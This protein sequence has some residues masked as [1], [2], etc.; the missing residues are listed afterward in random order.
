MSSTIFKPYFLDSLPG[1][2]G[3]ALL[4]KA[5]HNESIT[6]ILALHREVGRRCI[7]VAVERKICFYRIFRPL[8]YSWELLTFFYGRQRSTEF[9]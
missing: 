4:G 9:T 6:G 1:R 8:C 2:I 3:K 5:I 7:S